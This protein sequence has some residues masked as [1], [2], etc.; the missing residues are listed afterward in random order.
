LQ[1]D[2]EP[3]AVS[4]E[5]LKMIP[6]DKFKFAVI[7]FEHDY[8]ADLEKKIRNESR[9]Y[10]EEKGYIRVVGN[11]SMNDYCPYED[12][13]VHPDLVNHSKIEEVLNDNE[14]VVNIQKFMVGYNKK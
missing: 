2:C 9:A 4:F 11:V 3:P 13:W 14:S 10:L 7:T 8:Y 5:I 6:L 12:W 1:V